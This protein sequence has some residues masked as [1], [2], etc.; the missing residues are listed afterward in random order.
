MTFQL[1]YARADGKNKGTKNSSLTLLDRKANIFPLW[2]DI[3][4]IT[5][6]TDQGRI[7]TFKFKE[8]IVLT[9]LVDRRRRQGI[10]LK[11]K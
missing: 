8:I 7:D 6:A 3:L 5:R 1:K 9:S 11:E 10:C 2:K 4:T